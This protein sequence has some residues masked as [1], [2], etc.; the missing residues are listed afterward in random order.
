MSAHV[1]ALVTDA[2]GQGGGIAQYNRDLMAAIVTQMNNV[3]IDIVPRHVSGAIGTLPARIYQRPA[4]PGKIS[5]GLAAFGVALQTRPSA[6]FCGH[7]FTA[8]LAAVLARLT[9]AKLV[10]QMHGI[11]AWGE[12]S[13]LQRWAVE[14]ADLVLCV[15]R[16]TRGRVAQW[17]DV[18]P[19]RIAVLPNTVSD[20]YAPGDRSAARKHFDLGHQYVLLSVSR[21]DVRESYKGHDRV[22]PL[23]PAIIAQGHDVVYLIAG[24]GDD[25]PRL[26]ALVAEHGVA[27]RVRFLGHVKDENLVDLYRAADL[28]VLPSTGEGFGIV[29]LEAMACG[30]PALGLAA[31]GAVDALCDGELGTATPEEEFSAALSLLVHTSNASSSNL[32][33]RVRAKFGRPVFQ[34]SAETILTP[35]LAT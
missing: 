9:K 19:E 30:T 31:G 17:A 6:I 32:H 5:Y 21:L 1:L 35:L 13:Y 11:D 2:F 24:D 29:F 8:P 28:F 4:R 16:Y 20:G 12:P 7:I 3:E 33:A 25:R 22:I 23:L 15:S 18:A 27:D 14:Q 10:I 34:T 26:E